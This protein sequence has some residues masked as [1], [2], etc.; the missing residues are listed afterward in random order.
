MSSVLVR[1]ELLDKAFN[2][3]RCVPQTPILSGSWSATPPSVI[4]DVSP[5]SEFAVYA[6]R[7]MPV[8]RSLDLLQQLF[9]FGERSFHAM[10]FEFGV[11]NPSVTKLFIKDFCAMLSGDMTE[12][13]LDFNLTRS[14]QVRVAR[15]AGYDSA[16]CYSEMFYL[17]R[18]I[19]SPVT[20]NV[21]YIT[22]AYSTEGE[23]M[24]A[25]REA[26]DKLRKE[27]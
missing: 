15:K 24:R 23:L 4:V 12:A 2:L 5:R 27:L 6:P 16:D 26:V 9:P 7:T 8:A 18:I 13:M 11:T 21:L 20:P 25:A 10:R 17:L 22:S 1:D 19:P 3:F 14:W